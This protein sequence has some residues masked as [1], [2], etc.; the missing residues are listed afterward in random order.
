MHKNIIIVILTICVGI[1]SFAT[2]LNQKSS[3]T[4]RLVETGNYLIIIDNNQYLARNVFEINN[5]NSG[6]QQLK[7][8]KQIFNPYMESMNKIVVFDDMINIKPNTKTTA[9]LHAN[10]SLSINTVTP[11]S[12]Q[13]H[14]HGLIPSNDEVCKKNMSDEQF[15]DLKQVLRSTT[16]SKGKLNVMKQSIKFYGITSDQAKILVDILPFER[17]KLDLAKFSYTHTIDQ[18]NYAFVKNAL[19]YTMSKKSLDIHLYLENKN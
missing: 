11:L 1:T 5:I 9:T 19:K 17:D 13:K 4:I 15:K 12:I 2:S 14:K 6:I 10:R 7:I 18:Y 16:Y 3:L 8:V